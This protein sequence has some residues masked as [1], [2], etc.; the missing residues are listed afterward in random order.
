MTEPLTRASVSQMASDLQNS[1]R[2]RIK[3]LRM[4]GVVGERWEAEYGNNPSDS[5]KTH[6]EGVIEFGSQ[7]VPNGN[8][9]PP[10]QGR[11]P[12]RFAHQRLTT[13]RVIVHLLKRPAANCP[14]TQPVRDL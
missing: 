5:D 1:Y 7:V 13:P 4:S 14:R 9:F 3:S 6:Y 10:L 2:R 12:A 8:F 11:E